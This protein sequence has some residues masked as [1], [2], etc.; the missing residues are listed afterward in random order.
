MFNRKP[1]KIGTLS[2]SLPLEYQLQPKSS[3]R[4]ELPGPPG[5]YAT[6]ESRRWQAP[7]ARELHLVFWTPRAPYPGGPLQTVAEWDVKVAG[8]KTVILETSMFM[9]IQR[10]LLVTHLHPAD[11]TADVMIYV[12]GIELKEFK[13]ILAGIKDTKSFFS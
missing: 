2:I 8:Q 5:Y 7:E 4:F 3:R 11:P 1:W 10:R 13:T 6:E 9:G 12:E